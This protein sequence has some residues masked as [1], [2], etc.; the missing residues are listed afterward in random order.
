[1]V[2]EFE[3]S[4][5][6]NGRPG[7][8]RLL[9]FL[10]Q[11][12]MGSLQAAVD[13]PVRPADIVATRAYRFKYG[14]GLNCQQELTHDCGVFLRLGWNDGKTESFAFTA[15]DRLASAGV[16]VKGTRWH[17]K[18]DTAATSFGASGISGVHCALK[19]H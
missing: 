3:R 10:N 9:A 11:A 6:L 17:R 8:V 19:G 2:S 16:S 14:F 18:D 13:S 12:N 15:I 7:A 5:V 1:M 4:Y